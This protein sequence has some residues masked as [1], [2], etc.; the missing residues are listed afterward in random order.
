MKYKAI[1]FD[2]DGTLLDTLEDLKNAVN[3]ALNQKGFSGQH[4]LSEMRRFFGNGIL[5]ALRQAEPGA[6]E[7]ELS[8]VV[9]VFKEYYEQ[10]CL[11]NTRPYCGVSELVKKLKEEGYL[12]AIVSNKVD[13]A[14][15]ELAQRFFPE[16]TVA[17]GERTGIRRKPAPD[18]VFQAMK[19]LGVTVEEAV[20][21]GDSEVD[22]ATA[23]AA[24][25]PCISVL[26]GFRDRDMLTAEGAECFVETP[27]EIPGILMA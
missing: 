13:G 23:R 26:W 3:Y 14:V 11:D 19:E 4:T 2:L 5:Y 21:I 25:L 20:Y 9:S 8:G 1:I 15:K 7:E 22:L 24:G 12:M 6:S 27:E 18:T 10:H 17:I 16:I